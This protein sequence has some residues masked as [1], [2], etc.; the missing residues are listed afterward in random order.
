MTGH[1]EKWIR[2]QPEL[3]THIIDGLELAGFRLRRLDGEIGASRPIDRP[4]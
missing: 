3:V 2:G 4:R 1:I